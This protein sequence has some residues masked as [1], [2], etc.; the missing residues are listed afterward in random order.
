MNTGYQYG[1]EE[2]RFAQEIAADL[3]KEKKTPGDCPE[4]GKNE[5][6]LVDRA[7]N[8]PTDNVLLSFATRMQEQ[9]RNL[10]TIEMPEIIRLRLDKL[11][12]RLS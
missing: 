1:P 10:E 11:L 6:G 2:W 12:N 8:F 4:L 5:R 3:F 9:G 7:Y